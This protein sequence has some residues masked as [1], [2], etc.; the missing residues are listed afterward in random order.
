MPMPKNGSGNHGVNAGSNTGHGINPAN[1]LTSD[2]AKSVGEKDDQDEDNNAEKSVP[3]TLTLNDKAREIQGDRM[4]T[5]HQ[6]AM[7]RIGNNRT[8][9]CGAGKREHQ[10]LVE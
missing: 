7:D 10:E 5:Q 2:P 9:Q 3:P 4:L 1:V 6:E 8:P